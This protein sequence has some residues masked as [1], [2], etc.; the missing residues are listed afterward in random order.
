MVIMETPVFTR[1]I[2]AIMPDETYRALQEA[3]IRNPHLGAEIP[4]SGGL[5]KVRWLVPGKGKRGGARIIY[6]WIRRSEQI[7]M[8]LAYTKSRQDNLTEDQ[9][10]TL[11]ALVAQELNDGQ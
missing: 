2:Q 1:Q 5:R 11:N 8:L 7:Y 3:L 9:V 6:F 10:K 4:G